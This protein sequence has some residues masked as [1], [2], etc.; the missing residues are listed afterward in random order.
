MNRSEVV[1]DIFRLKHN[2]TRRLER[3]KKNYGISN[4]AVSSYEKL[5]V[6]KSLR[7][8]DLDE[9]RKIRKELMSYNERKFST[10]K[11]YKKFLEFEDAFEGLEADEKQRV[12]EL[13]GKFVEEKRFL[14]NYKYEALQVIAENVYQDNSDLS[15]RR[16]INK[17]YEES[18][19]EE[20]RYENEQWEKFYEAT[21]VPKRLRKY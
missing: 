6:P 2:I 20:Q 19:T 4:S 10:V 21:N 16:K 14:Q 11:G 17:L 18:L 8:V 7:G 9:L 13:Y 3:V 12:W 1:K 5:D 15:I